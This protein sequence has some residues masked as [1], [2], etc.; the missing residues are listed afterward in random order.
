MGYADKSDRDDDWDEDDE[1]WDEQESWDALQARL[2]MLEAHSLK[3]S[4]YMHIVAQC[5]HDIRTMFKWLTYT[6]ALP[7]GYWI[8][9]AVHTIIAGLVEVLVK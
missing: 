8:A 3:I 5:A 7:F 1:D 9:S 6:A 4:A 2:K